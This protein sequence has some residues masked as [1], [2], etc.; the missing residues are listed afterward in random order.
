MNAL[1]SMDVALGLDGGGGSLRGKGLK[2]KHPFDEVGAHAGDPMV[3]V[4]DDTGS[5]LCPSP[6]RK[7][8]ASAADSPQGA[9]RQPPMGDAPASPFV[10][11]RSHLTARLEALRHDQGASGDDASPE[12]WRGSGGNVDSSSPSIFT[13]TS[14][15]AYVESKPSSTAKKPKSK[16]TAAG[17]WGAGGGSG[18][19]EWPCTELTFCCFLPTVF[20][21]FHSALVCSSS[22][23]SARVLQMGRRRR[24]SSTPPRGA[25]SGAW[26][27]RSLHR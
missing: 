21:S 16:G 22:K 14:Y 5:Q 6:H 2:A 12:K 20:R 24:A 10:S 11:A 3:W 25:R 4:D 23:P 7:L 27:S 17:A 1:A 15:A 26:C 9:W 13:A 18:S 19:G 8:R